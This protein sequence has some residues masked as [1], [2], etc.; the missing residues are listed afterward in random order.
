MS[1]I[2]LNKTLA[3]GNHKNPIIFLHVI[4]ELRYSD[5]HNL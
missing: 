5:F 3:Q 2:T 1:K 4:L